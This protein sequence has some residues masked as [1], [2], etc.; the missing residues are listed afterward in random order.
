MTIDEIPMTDTNNDTW[1]PKFLSL[2][3][4]GVLEHQMRLGLRG[5]ES[6]LVHGPFGAGKTEA[7]KHCIQRLETEQL[8]AQLA[9]GAAPASIV[10]YE[11]SRAT[12]PKTALTDIYIAL[13]GRP[14]GK[15]SRQDWTPTQF[16]AQIAEHTADANVRLIVID[17]AHQIDAG[18][19]DLLRQLPDAAARRGHTLRFVLVG[20]AGLTQNVAATGQDGERFTGDVAFPPMSPE[21]VGPHLAGF[22]PGLAALQETLSAKAWRQLQLAMFATAAGSFRRLC[23]IIANAHEFALKRGQPMC[24]RDVQLAI[25]KIRTRE[26]A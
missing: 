9:T 10:T 19:I 7:V 4:H 8:R 1:S 20:N 17:E 11:S 2:P 5:V 23:A 24:E 26:A 25:E 21:H 16:I 22:H 6:T 3:I 14:M 13:T 18:N 12:G 15:R